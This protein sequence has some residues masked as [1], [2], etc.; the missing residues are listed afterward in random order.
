[1]NTNILIGNFIALLAAFIIIYYGFEKN[2]K[3]I[4][5]A[6]ILE[7]VLAT[8]YNFFLKGYTALI[9]DILNIFL[10][11][12]GFKEKLNFKNKL[13]INIV[14]I[15]LALKFNNLGIIGYIPI[16]VILIYSWGLN[17]KNII[18]FKLLNM[19][20]MLLWIIHD[21]TVK[22]YPSVVCEFIGIIGS[23]YSIY[24]IKKLKLHPFIPECET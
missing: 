10:L 1:M 5:I 2:K 23:I 13:I 22:S 9:V 6:Q 14:A 19:L 4:L 12:L 18:K 17:T 11:V 7:C 8:C 21:L 15:I 20:L 3:R 16:I 24:K